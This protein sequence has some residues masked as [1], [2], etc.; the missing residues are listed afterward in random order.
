[1]SD[2]YDL[3]GAE[4]FDAPGGR[5]VW[6]AKGDVM[7]R[8]SG[9]GAPSGQNRENPDV[10]ECTKTGIYEVGSARVKYF[11]GDKMPKQA[12]L[13]D[14]KAGAVHPGGLATEKLKARG[15]RI[16]AERASATGSSGRGKGK[17][18]PTDDAGEAGQQ[19]PS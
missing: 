11:S 5:K 17:S 8:A 19:P 1:M 7:R 9:S 12:K 10:Q 6:I 14:G 3:S 16:A 13:V 4:E 15:A 18:K 2:G